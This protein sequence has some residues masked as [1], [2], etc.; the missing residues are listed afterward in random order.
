MSDAVAQALE[1][2][3]NQLAKLQEE[4]E[5]PW[6]EKPVWTTAEAQRYLGIRSERT[7]RDR[8]KDWGIVPCGSGLW[9]ARK[10]CGALEKLSR[11]RC[12][13]GK[14]QLQTA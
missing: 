9:P 4:R 12:K 3:S 2:L 5:F 14:R 1:H 10:I 13:S 6:W 8:M 7:F 11:V